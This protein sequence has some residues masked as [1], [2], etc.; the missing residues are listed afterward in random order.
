MEGEFIMT[1]PIRILYIIFIGPTSLPPSP[2]PTPLKEIARGFLV[3]FHIGAQYSRVTGTGE[4][5]LLA[6]TFCYRGTVGALVQLMQG[7]MFLWRFRV[8]VAGRVAAGSM[9]LQ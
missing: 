3:L 9:E 6:C 8:K 2:L 7:P 1:I 4:S 5:S